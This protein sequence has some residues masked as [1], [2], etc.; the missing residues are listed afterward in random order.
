VWS[1]VRIRAV[2]ESADAELQVEPEDG[3]GLDPLPWRCRKC[4]WIDAMPAERMMGEAQSSWLVC[5]ACNQQRLKHDP[6]PLSRYYLLRGLRLVSA[7]AKDRIGAYDA[8][9]TRCGTPRRVSVTT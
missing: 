1:A 4:G 6:T 9:C 3:D 8:E 5:H 2:F 7:V